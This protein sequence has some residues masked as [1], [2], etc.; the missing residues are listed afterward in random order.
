MNEL[1]KK[2]IPQPPTADPLQIE[3]GQWMGRREAFGLMAG[4]CSAADVEI[5]RRIKD[6][7]LYASLDCTWG[8]FCTGR[9]HMPRRTVDR[10]I[11]YL[12]DFGPAFFTVRQLTRIN[13]RDYRAISAHITEEG[14]N[15]DGNTIRLLPENNAP[16]AAAV[17]ELLQRTGIRD[18]HAATDAFDALLRRCQAVEQA[19]RSFDQPMDEHQRIAITRQGVLIRNAA[20]ELGAIFIDMQLPR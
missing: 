1:V 12:R 16:V 2:E 18:S 15:V 19:L 10:E 9:L 3:I 5:L 14:V 6:D 20:V 11:G 8:E 4:R 13:V 17:E 7:Q